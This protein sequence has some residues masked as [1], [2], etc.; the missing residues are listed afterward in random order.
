M[1]MKFSV[2]S[3]GGLY[4][5]YYLKNPVLLQW[6]EQLRLFNEKAHPGVNKSV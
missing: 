5:P 3:T 1:F 4:D 2:K 6:E